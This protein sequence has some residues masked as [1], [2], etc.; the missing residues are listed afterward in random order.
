MQPRSW[1][2]LRFLIAIKRGQTLGAAA[3]QL[4]VDDTTV[5]RRL[6]ALQSDVGRH[7]VRRQGDGKWMLTAA[8]ELVAREAEAM[9]HHFRLLAAASDDHDSYAGTVRITSVPILANRVFASSAQ[10]LL[11]SKPGL[12][13]ELVPDSRDF[14]VTRR[15]ADIA[16]R[17]ARPST[18]GLSVK[19]RRIGT[20]DYAAYASATLTSRK[21]RCLPWIT[22]EDGMSHLP[23]A[24]WIA[25]LVRADRVSVAG[26]RVH[27][28]ETAL[29][30]AV[31]GLGKT[32]LPTLVAGRDAR[33]HRL[34]IDA[35]RPYPSRE[36]WLLV[37]ADQIAVRAVSAAVEW[38]E[39]VVSSFA[40]RSPLQVP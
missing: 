25:S 9:E 32:L 40:L 34:R 22:Y 6:A 12:I 37:H 26:L 23:Q 21:V 38:I 3:R 33:L 24:K 36:I 31:A 19:T 5:S 1:D 7:L 16:V 11:V 17:L 4:E 30:A 27:D 2:D 14:N 20:L 39:T 28:A 13:I 18:G 10:S 29:E 15:E 8:G 35:A